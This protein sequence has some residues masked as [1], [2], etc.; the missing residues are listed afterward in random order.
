MALQMATNITP[1]SFAG[2]GGANFDANEGLSV[3]WQ[4]N[5]SPYLLAY[6]ITI[7]AMDDNSTQMYTTGKVTLP[8]PF[9]GVLADGAVQFFE[10]NEISASELSSAGITNGNEYKMYI[11]QWWGNTDDDSVTQQNASVIRA[12]SVPTV[13][14]NTFPNPI[15]QRMYTFAAT[16]TQAQNDE[17][18]W[19][20]WVLYNT[21]T[22]TVIVDTGEIY[23]T[24]QLQ[25]S[26]DALF[27]GTIY[28]IE[29]TI[30]TQS[31]QQCTSGVQ[32]VNVSYSTN[33]ES[34]SLIAEQKCEWNGISVSWEPSTDETTSGYSLYRLDSVTNLY[35]KIADLDITQTGI[36]DY[37][38]KNGHTYTYQLWELNDT[39]FVQ[40]P[41]TSNQI[42][43]CSWNV[44]LIAAAVDGNGVYHPQNV[45]AFGSSVEMGEESNNSKNTVF[46]TF[47]G[48]PA[49]QQSSNLYRTGK[50]TAFIGKIDRTTNQYVGD[51]SDYLD[52]IMTLTTSN[53]TMFIRDRKGNFREIKINGSVSTRV[54]SSWANQASTI[55]I[56][57]VEVADASDANVILTNTDGLWPYDE[58][59]DTTV[60]IDPSTGSLMWTIP[61]NYITD[62]KGSVLFVNQD[63]HLIQSYSGTV[64]QMADLSIDSREHLIS[65]Q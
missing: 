47:T 5:G 27:A 65:K 23:G 26:Y 36:V 21:Q 41:I 1:D 33:T 7:Y 51:T 20:R 64:V 38:A 10:A 13:V 25:F 3:S 11:T 2:I 37:S 29:I 18:A 40:Q 6:Q 52:E 50:L 39:V 32:T 63:G 17:I 43:P 61:D 35:K 14:I 57:W 59:A 60:E 19:V 44:L 4:V 49:Y 48:Y 12:L 9:Y 54:Q 58:I 56:P 46:D 55:T 34:G 45:Y 30:E 8:S 15:T 53:L 28:G 62:E 22:E 31:G 16:Y 42:T 24:S